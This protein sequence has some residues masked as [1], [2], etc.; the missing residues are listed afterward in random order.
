MDRVVDPTLTGVCQCRDITAIRLNAATAMPIHGGEVG[1]GHDHFVAE[2]LQVLRHTSL[3]VA[4]SR[5]MRMRG[6]P[7]NTAVK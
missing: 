5:R 4:A 6:R 3:S 1:I 7:Q 2:R